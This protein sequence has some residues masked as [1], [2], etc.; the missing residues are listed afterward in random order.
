MTVSMRVMSA[1]NGYKYVLK[2]VAAGDGDRA[3]STPLTRYY[4]EAGCPPGRW[5]GSG[6]AS[7]QLDSLHAGDAVT[8]TQLQLLIGQGRNPVTGEDLGR[9]Y[10]NHRG[11]HQR[12]QDRA[13]ALDPALSAQERAAA[14]RQIT[15]EEAEHGTRRTVAGYDYTFSVPKSVSVLW[16]LADAGTQEL[17]TQAHHHAVAEALDFM[18]REIVATRIGASTRGGP[19]AQADVTGVLA[20]VYDHWDSRAGDPQLHSHVLVSNKT[21][22]A[23]DGRWRAVDGRPMHA[24]TV[25]VSQLFNAALADQLSRLFGLSWDTRDRGQDRNPAWEIAGVGENLIGEF[26]ARSAD[27]DAEVARLIAAHK[28]DHGRQP[29][30]RAIIRLRQQATLATRPDKVLRS[31]AEL[32]AEWR[33]RATGLL[34]E[35]ATGWTR[36]LIASGDTLVIRADD[37]PLDVIENLGQTVVQNVAEKRSTWTRWTLHAEASRQTMGWRF[38]AIADREAVTAMIADAAE[39]HCLRLTPAELSVPPEFQR[40]DGTSRFRPRH[41]ALFSSQELLDAETRLLDLSR[42]ETGPTLPDDVIEQATAPPDEAERFLSDDQAA[43]LAAIA[44]SG[45][46]VDVLVGPAGAG[47]TTALAALR[48]AW[49]A[50]HGIGSV[51]G[52]APS[53]TAA[54]VLGEDLGIATENTAKW[55]TDHRLH[56]DTFTAGQ[57]VIVDEASLAGTF[58]LDQ[59]A[60]LAA[61]AGAK[62][63]LVGDWAQLQAVDA[64]GAF[65]LLVSDRHDAPELTDIHRFRNDWEKAASLALRHGRPDAIT[66]YDEH[67]RITGGEQ[68][69][70]VENAYLAWRADITAG[71]ASLLIAEDR[72]TVRD[73]NQRARNERI[74]ARQVQH[75]HAVT[76]ADGSQA[77]PGDLVITRRNDR[78]LVAGRTGWVRNGDRWTVT[79]VYP[80]GSVTI[81]RAGMDTGG[82]VTLPAAYAADHLDLGYAVTSFRAQGVTVDTAHTV[83]TA[84]TN[85]ENLY[86][87]MTRGRDANTAY[88]AIDRPDDTHGQPHPSDDPNATARSVLTSVLARVG[89]DLS[90]HQAIDAEHETW[91]NIAQLGAEYE[92]LAAAALQDRWAALI[93]STLPED[94]AESVLN[95]EAFGALAADLHRAMAAGWNPEAEFPRV[96][97]ARSLP[98]GGD[99]ASV[100][101]GRLA[102]VIDNV[103][104]RP[105]HHRPAYILGMFPEVTDPASPAMAA[106]LADRKTAMETR[107]ANLLRQAMADRSPWLTALGP[108]STDHASA[109][110][111]ARAALAAATYR[112][113]YQIET[114][115]PFGD[116]T[117]LVQRRDAAR[118]R[119]MIAQLQQ[120]PSEQTPLVERSQGLML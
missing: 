53:A 40:A 87:A 83:V 42:D 41:L 47:K 30:Q 59:L 118:I 43:A 15:D 12:V 94:Q 13:A 1:G 61:D 99:V 29:S 46:V 95:S 19:A 23:Q 51:V 26:S 72:A 101:H 117:T 37:V 102:G 66:A 16:G 77:S 62:M 3:L 39:S 113:R 65:N 84:T 120:R 91:N 20:T 112:D 55:L 76:L 111:W 32:T 17:I 5:A 105:R 109:R 60:R 107:A 18:E 114:L 85:R 67:G 79:Q 36:K 2:S 34:G 4:A 80:D 75:D 64:G 106:A 96:V 116:P 14:V 28:A 45:R 27:I 56:G 69:A 52:L 44:T 100:L 93:R 88:V 82:N 57:L 81:R 89:A 63:L 119:A 22:T 90:A 73:L 110:H 71:R 86:V 92:T 38:A 50:G 74:I 108:R 33:D 9:P 54:A 24:A 98:D 58:T 104:S 97:A 115:T 70:I 6:V 7:L 49:E 31:L 48:R 25:A 103:E 35:D 78:R 10:L 68:D 8:E 11:V 21:C